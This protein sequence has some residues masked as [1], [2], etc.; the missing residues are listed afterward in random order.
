MAEFER[1][2]ALQEA[3]LWFA[4]CHR[5]V[6]TVEE[7]AEFECWRSKRKNAAAMNELESAWELTGLARA[8]F[9]ALDEPAPEGQRTFARTAVL[10]VMCVLSL[11]VGIV[12]YSGHSAFWTSL[13]W[14]QR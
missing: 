14:V 1:D 11:G 8:H 7:R 2:E 10:A 4:R 13:D 5:G 12:T 9:T 3:A 6:M